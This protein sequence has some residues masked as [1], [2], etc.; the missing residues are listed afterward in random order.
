MHPIDLDRLRAAGDGYPAVSLL[1]S[2]EVPGQALSPPDT[3]R[4]YHLVEQV[5]RR[6]RAELGEAMAAELVGRLSALAARVSSQAAPPGLGLFVGDSLSLAVASPTPVGERV[7]IDSTF[8]L[9]ELRQAVAR[10]PRYRV[11]VLAGDRSRIFEG[12]GATLW[13]SPHPVPVAGAAPGTRRR[14][15]GHRFGVERSDIREEGRR[16]LM[17]A[18][19]GAVAGLAREDPLPLVLV[20]APRDLSLF[21][22][23][24]AQGPS[25]AGAVRGSH[26]RAH[27]ARLLRLVQPVVDA[28]L[29]ERRRRALERLR[30]AP[31]ERR[32]S[33]M[34]RIW[35]LAMD[36][37]VDLV[38]VEEGFS[39][40]ARVDAGRLVPAAD[41]EAPD[42]LDDAVDEA[43]EAV[44]ARGG[45]SVQVPDGTLA[46]HGRIAAVL[47]PGAPVRPSPVPALSG[48]PGGTR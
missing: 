7:A 46:A 40:P 22:A 5:E 26:G 25:I 3:I 47:R 16:Q 45:E 34:D 41:R 8:A 14:Q 35:G 12:V 44:A 33:G 4:L 27:P 30:E 19:D 9:R 6:L 32:A 48:G 39:H 21:R 42:V 43:I 10:T 2:P 36:G 17:A 37:W 23:V 20:G 38:C 24:T 11:L 29:E 18:L 13:P 31:G 28:H 1:L 15:R